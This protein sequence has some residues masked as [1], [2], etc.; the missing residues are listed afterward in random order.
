MTLNTDLIVY[1]DMRNGDEKDAEEIDETN[2]K[3][4]A[5]I[6]DKVCNWPGLAYIT[7]LH[8]HFHFDIGINYLTWDDKHLQGLE[9]SI[10]GKEF[11][12]TEN[13]FENHRKFFEQLRNL[14]DYKYIVGDVSGAN[15]TGV[16][17]NKDLDIICKFIESHSFKMDYR[18]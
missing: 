16:R 15:G 12:R 18:K 10:S 5:L 14:V 1:N 13:S 17:V 3:N 7:Y 8:P 6:I 4:E 11:G 9:I 2:Y